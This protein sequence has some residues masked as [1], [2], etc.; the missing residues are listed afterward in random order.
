MEIF[1]G[2]TKVRRDMDSENFAASCGIKIQRR[3]RVMLHF[4]TKIQD[5][6]AKSLYVRLRT[7]THE[8]TTKL[9]RIQ[10]FVDFQHFKQRRLNQVRYSLGLDSRVGSKDGAY[11]GIEEACAGT[12]FFS[13]KK[14]ST[15]RFL[16]FFMISDIRK[17]P[18][19]SP[20][21]QIEFK[22]DHKNHCFHIP[23]ALRSPWPQNSGK[24]S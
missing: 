9:L 5:K 19:F 1:A 11:C 16:F 22:L 2:P 15:C 18:L 10:A 21:F 13:S 6:T 4:N 23:R 14:M 17:K 8:A 24:S 20:Q 12:S 7:K 3:N